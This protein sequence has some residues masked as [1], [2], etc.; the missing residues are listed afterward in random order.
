MMQMMHAAEDLIRAAME[1]LEGGVVLPRPCMDARCMEAVAAQKLN[2][3]HHIIQWI[4]QLQ[5]ID[6]DQI[7]ILLPQHTVHTV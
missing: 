5:Q 6:L 1:L 4:I 3:A 2:S 7:Q